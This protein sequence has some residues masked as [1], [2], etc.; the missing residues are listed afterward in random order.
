[1]LNP[2]V[3]IQTKFFEDLSSTCLLRREPDRAA[4]SRSCGP[5]G[6]LE[7]RPDRPDRCRWFCG[8]TA[9]LARPRLQ[10]GIRR[11]P[12]LCAG[13]RFASRRLERVCADRARLPEKISGRDE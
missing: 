5:G 4:L 11:V 8:G 13:R 1:M 3:S 6:N 9:P 12:G 10:P 7:P 2:T